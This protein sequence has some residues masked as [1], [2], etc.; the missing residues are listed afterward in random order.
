MN[1]DVFRLVVHRALPGYQRVELF[2]LLETDVWSWVQRAS[3][4]VGCTPQA[5]IEMAVVAYRRDAKRL[6]L[7]EEQPDLPGVTTGICD[8]RGHR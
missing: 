5:I 7:L 3:L 6:G 4:K 8:G 2:L 1:D